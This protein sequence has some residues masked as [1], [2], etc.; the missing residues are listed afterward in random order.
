MTK[1]KKTTNKLTKKLGK[2]IDDHSECG[3][4]LS[5]QDRNGSSMQERPTLIRNG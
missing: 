2:W 4:W 1:F 5:Y 3:E